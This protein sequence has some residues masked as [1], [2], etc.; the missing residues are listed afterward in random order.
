MSIEDYIKSNEGFRKYPYKD[1]EGH[2]TIGYGINLE[3]GIE[4]EVASF[5][6]SK[7]VQIA[8]EELNDIIPLNLLRTPTNNRLYAMT[9][10]MYNLG[11][12]K[13]L[14]FK[15][16]IQAIKDGNWNKAADELLD[17]KYALQTGKRAIE[18]ANRLKNG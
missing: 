8:M 9:D 7:R 15:K 11:K 2:L 10:M 5:W 13:F 16:M 3:E 14:T 1:S 4:E 17:S 6:I 12:T 18:N